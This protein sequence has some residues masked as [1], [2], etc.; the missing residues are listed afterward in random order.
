MSETDVLACPINRAP[1]ISVGVTSST[2]PSFFDEAIVGSSWVTATLEEPA[3]PAPLPARGSLVDGSSIRVLADGC[4]LRFASIGL[5][6]LRSPRLIAEWCIK[7]VDP[8]TAAFPVLEAGEAAQVLARDRYRISLDTLSQPPL[9][10]AAFM[11]I[12][13]TV[14][15]KPQVTS[16]LR[17]GM[18]RQ[19]IVPA[20]DLGSSID[21]EVV[22]KDDRPGIFSRGTDVDLRLADVF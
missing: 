9:C 6:E 20:S 1:S 21:R 16:A 4:D 19:G 2:G 11:L 15:E 17:R 13:G 8:A 22:Q 18:H 5:D 12:K 10:T 7:D 14:A 3:N